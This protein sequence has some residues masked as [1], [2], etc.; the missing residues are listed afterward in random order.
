MDLNQTLFE[1]P[2]LL[3]ENDVAYAVMGGL[4]VRVY[5]IPRATQD[6]DLTITIERPRLAELF[7]KLE[8]QGFSIPDAY[9]SGWVDSVADIPLVK[10]RRYLAD[11]GVDVDLF[12]AETAYQRTL[13][14]RRRFAEIDGHSVYLVSPEDLILLKLIAGRPRDLIDVHDILFTLGQLDRNYLRKWAQELGV[15]EALEQALSASDT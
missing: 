10:L 2:R 13:M 7:D 11:R 6:I 9:R 14:T 15:S 12:L 4:A 8:Q 1:L 5:S 3:D